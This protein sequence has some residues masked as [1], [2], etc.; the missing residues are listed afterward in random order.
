NAGIAFQ[1]IGGGNLKYDDPAGSINNAISANTGQ[2]IELDG[3]TLIA[4]GFEV[5][6]DVTTTNTSSG[7]SIDI[8]N[9][10][11]ANVLLDSI[12]IAGTGIVLNS[13]ASICNFGSTTINN[14][15]GAGIAILGSNGNVNFGDVDITGL[16]ANTGL[17]LSDADFDA[18]VIFTTLNITGTGLAGSKGIDLS[19]IDS[20][21]NISINMPSTISNVQIGVDLSN[22][23]LGLG[24]GLPPAGAIFRYGDGANPKQSSIDTSGI[25]AN[26]SIEITGLNT[27]NGAYDFIDVELSNTSNLNSSPVNLLLQEPP[28]TNLS[29]NQN[30]ASEAGETIIVITATSSETVFNAQTVTINVK[31]TNVLNTDYTLS[32][33]GMID[34]NSGQNS[35]SITMTIVN[36]DLVEAITENAV[37][38]ISGTSIGLTEGLTISQTVAITDNDAATISISDR[39]RNEGNGGGNRD[40]NF[41]VTLN[42]SVDTD[43]AIDFATTDNTATTAD[44]DYLNQSGTLTFS[45]NSSAGATKIITIVGLHD[46]STEP[47][48]TFFVDLSNIAATGRNVTFS[49]NQG[50]GTIRDDEPDNDNDG[51][52]DTDDPDDDNDGMPDTW[53]DANGLDSFVNDA[54]GD[55]DN[56]NL[57]NLE[58]FQA[59]TNPQVNNSD[60]DSHLDGD[61]NCPL[62]DNEDQADADNNGIGDI[63]DEESDSFCMPIKASSGG[64][65][66]I[67]L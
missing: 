11:G 12:N 6:G 53:E 30:T 52:S 47:D 2:A 17:D 32:D 23:Q 66:I 38:E 61:D 62:D 40:Y 37:I 8:N 64:I 5:S 13:N 18:Q 42:K 65:V 1:A 10:S 54:A 44:S 48:E 22:A 14:P 39:L 55:D 34:I 24:N 16:T 3:I 29:V 27:T 67:C 19:S 7:A 46:D 33:G 49:D 25:A 43:V 31:G 50:L 59:G 21:Q 15:T 56:D 60:N 45:A 41:T 51:I 28:N 4:P 57:S 58:E 26:K 20:N 36:D 63:C 9:V 35:G